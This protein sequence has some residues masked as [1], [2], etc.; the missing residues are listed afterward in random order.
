MRVYF[1]F[2][3]ILAASLNDF[4]DTIISIVL[5]T[6]DFSH[7]HI[8]TKVLLIMN[9]SSTRRVALA[10]VFAIISCSTNSNAFVN[11]PQSQPVQ[12]SST[13]INGFMDA[14]KNDDSLGAVQN[15]GLSGGPR[16]ND[17]FTVNGKAGKYTCIVYVC[18]TLKCA[19]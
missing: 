11:I 3:G 5:L 14:F 8:I 7:L 10:A 1:F 16:Y 19:Y 18:D 12:T 4:D 9:K 6:I 13:S 15:A 17:Q 2:K